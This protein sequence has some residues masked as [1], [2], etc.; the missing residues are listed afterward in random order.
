MCGEITCPL[1]MWIRE[2]IQRQPLLHFQL[3]TNERDSQIA[4]LVRKLVGII[5]GMLRAQ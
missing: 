5:L 3:G 4:G 2:A 1:P